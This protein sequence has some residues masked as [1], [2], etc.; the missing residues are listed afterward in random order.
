M[1]IALGL[2]FVL[3]L[4]WVYSIIRVINA[5]NEFER[6]LKQL[7]HGVRGGGRPRPLDEQRRQAWEE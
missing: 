4:F 6:S 3:F 2:L 1:T 5:I 7:V